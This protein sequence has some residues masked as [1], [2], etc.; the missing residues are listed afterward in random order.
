MRQYRKMERQASWT[1]EDQTE[2]LKSRDAVRDRFESLGDTDMSERLP[3]GL[4]EQL[5]KL[6]EF[7]AI[8]SLSDARLEALKALIYDTN[9]IV[10]R[11]LVSLKRQDV[12]ADNQRERERKEQLHVFLGIPVIFVFLVVSMVIIGTQL[13]L[14][15]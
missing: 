1:A 3:Y 15:R 11:W 9:E 12:W 2:F 14:N 5:W 7:D 6:D 4:Q 8:H 10:R 13:Y